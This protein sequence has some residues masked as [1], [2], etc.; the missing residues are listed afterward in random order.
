MSNSAT[1]WTITCQAHLFMAF[2]RQEYWSGLACPS[3]GDLP[4]PG[5]KPRSPALQADSSPSESLLITYNL[6]STKI[7]LKE[8]RSLVY[9]YLTGATLV[10]IFLQCLS[11]FLYID[12]PARHYTHSSAWSFIMINII[13]QYS[14][15]HLANFKITKFKDCRTPYIWI[16]F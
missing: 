5:I 6:E 11:L 9:S 7:F 2:S 8:N 1:L 13:E 15:H 12:F 14:P 16:I 3:P 10:N 4:H